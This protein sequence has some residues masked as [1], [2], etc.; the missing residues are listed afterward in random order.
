MDEWKVERTTRSKVGQME[1]GM[2]GEMDG[3]KMG[4]DWKELHV[5]VIF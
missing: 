1:A 3:Q 5:S 2:E 4:G